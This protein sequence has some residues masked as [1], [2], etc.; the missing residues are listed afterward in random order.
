MKNLFLANCLKVKTGEEGFSARIENA[1]SNRIKANRNYDQLT[2][3]K[4]KKALF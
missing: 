1:M 4:L 2:P 3:L